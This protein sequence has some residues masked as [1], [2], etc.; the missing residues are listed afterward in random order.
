MAIARTDEMLIHSTLV[1]ESRIFKAIARKSIPQPSVRLNTPTINFK[2][3]IFPLSHIDP[4]PSGY[5]LRSTRIS[6]TI[7]EIAASCKI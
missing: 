7:L 2:K 1:N 4:L 6:S 3:P 5:K